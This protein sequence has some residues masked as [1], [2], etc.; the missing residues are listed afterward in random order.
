MS[1]IKAKR[2]KLNVTFVNYGA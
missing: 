2:A 1:A